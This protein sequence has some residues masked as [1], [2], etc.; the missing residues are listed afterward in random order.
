MNYGYYEKDFSPT[1][2]ITDEDE[3]YPIQLYHFLAEKVSFKNLDVLE[4]GSGRGGGASYLAKTFNPK[5]ICGIDISSNAIDLCNSLYD[6]NNLSFKVGDSE[7]LPFLNNSID[8]IFNIESSHCYPSFENFIDEIIRVLKPGGYF[9][10]C[11]LLISKNYNE[12]IKCFN[13]KYLK[14]ISNTDITQNVI[15]ASELM[16]ESRRNLINNF[17]SGFLKNVLLS[18]ASVKG[19]KIF[20]SFQE[21]H[22]KYISAVCQKKN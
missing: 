4:V 10:Y 15:N 20:K 9:V 17:S 2:S 18:F 19:S 5:S 22:Y 13:K 21:G 12:H 14:L 16:T 11:D 1:L 6:Q 7:N 8:V 3:R